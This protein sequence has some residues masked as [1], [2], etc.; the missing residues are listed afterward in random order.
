LSKFKLN[1]SEC[2]RYFIHLRRDVRYRSEEADRRAIIGGLLNY[3][4]RNGG[5]C[6][7]ASRTCMME[8]ARDGGGRRRAQGAWARGAQGH[9][10]LGDAGVTSTN[11]NAPTMMIS[12]KGAAIIKVPRGK[13]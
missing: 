8:V 9:R 11:T 1:I 6:Y 13:D 12:E 2:T 5:T 7:H 3:A 10:R 4:R